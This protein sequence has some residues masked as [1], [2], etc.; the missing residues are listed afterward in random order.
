MALVLYSTTLFYP[1]GDQAAG[2]SVV[3][4]H[5]ASNQ[6]ALLFTDDTGT[7]PA[8]NPVT[9]NSEGMLSF[10]SAPGT[11]A[12]LLAGNMFDVPVDPSIT[13][14]VF[15]GLWVHVQTVPATVW[16]VEHHFGVRP[17]V[18]LIIS[19]DDAEAAVHHVDDETTTI[20]FGSAIT[21]TAH[22][23]R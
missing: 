15:P 4:W 9:T 2:V 12:V 22:L 5:H 18:D 11:Y 3:V 21:G 23:R 7:T 14:P 20:T 19:D 10:Y 17:H 1:G 16:T 8:A 6:A 13:D